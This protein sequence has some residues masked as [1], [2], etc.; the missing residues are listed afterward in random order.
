[1]IRNEFLSSIYC[2][3]ELYSSKK[4]KKE[5]DNLVIQHI[6]FMVTRYTGDDHLFKKLI[7]SNNPYDLRMGLF[8]SMF[9]SDSI[10]KQEEIVFMM[11]NSKDFS[12]SVIVFDAVHYRDYIPFSKNKL[13]NLDKTIYTTLKSIEND[14]RFR[15]VNMGKLINILN[16]Y[17]EKCFYK[18]K[19]MIKSIIDKTKNNSKMNSIEKEFVKLFDF[20]IKE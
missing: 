20:S 13:P 4:K 9:L 12:K 8:S 18:R 3:Y 14:D 10:N 7:K 15:S 1:V 5:E 19:S 6:V 17:G 2:S 16:N 11:N